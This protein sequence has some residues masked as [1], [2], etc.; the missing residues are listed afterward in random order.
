MRNAERLKKILHSRDDDD[1]GQMETKIEDVRLRA[2][3]LWQS[4]IEAHQT[5]SLRLSDSEQLTMMIPFA[6]AGHELSFSL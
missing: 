2:F 6:L 3:L 5:V 4:L 1:D